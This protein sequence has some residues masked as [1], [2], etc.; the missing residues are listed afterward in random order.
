MTIYALGDAIPQIHPEAF[1]HP[2]AVV[3]GAVTIGAQASIWP[4]AVLR[5]DHGRIEVGARTSIQDGTVLHTTERWPTVVGAECVV[6]H[7]A[8]L[9]G[10]AVGDRCLVG[11]GSIVLNRA[12]VE[13]GGAVGAAAL[14]SEGTTVPTGQIALGVPA[15][16][17][18]APNRMAEWIAEAVA[19]YLHSAERH[20]GE[21][22]R[23]DEG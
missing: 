9:E 10:C 5:G 23:V 12:V 1:V 14:V 6:G 17:R 19:T 3:I 11:S 7:N 2:D 4:A 13:P 18:P 16:C 15:R 20:R 21:L 8:H 22:R